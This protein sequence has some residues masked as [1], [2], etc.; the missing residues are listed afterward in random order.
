MTSRGYVVLNSVL[1][2]AAAFS[3]VQIGRVYMSPSAS[4]DKRVQTAK[5]PGA[6]V[7]SATSP[8]NPG[9]RPGLTSYAVIPSKNLFNP[10]RSDSDTVVAAAAPPA[11]KP[12]LFGV[13]LRD[14]VSIAYLEDPATK[15]VAGYRI[16]EAVGG[17]TVQTIAADRVVLKRAEGLVDV[18]LRDPG[19]PRPEPAPAA[20]G[21]QPGR[22]G[23]QQPGAAG[24]A[25]PQP[26]VRPGVPAPTTAVPR[27]NLL[28][29]LP[30]PPA[31]RPAA[32]QDVP[33]PEFTNQD[34]PNQ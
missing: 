3:A 5:P 7:P 23:A 28:R 33:N 32:G 2:V 8:S 13:V 21:A 16:G 34:A 11:P 20:Q 18:Q 30:L 29:R 22:P 25:V 1:A 4:P 19:K 12:F 27:P 10:N 17:G 15:R 24:A 31:T 9:A 14:D 6:I 26:V